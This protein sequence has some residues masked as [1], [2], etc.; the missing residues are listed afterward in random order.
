MSESEE[1]FNLDS[2]S[3]EGKDSGK[4]D[5]VFSL[6]HHMGTF[7]L[8]ARLGE[9]NADHLRKSKDTI[10]RLKSVDLS[11]QFASGLATLEEKLNSVNPEEEVNQGTID[12][13]Q[14]IWD[15]IH[16]LP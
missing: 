11:E 14:R 15:S 12:D 8:T 9:Y 7:L 6:G 4:R 16:L 3:G 1:D 13:I 5:L 10:V 2:N